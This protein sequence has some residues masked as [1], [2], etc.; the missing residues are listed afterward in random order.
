MPRY[1]F[2]SWDGDRFVPDDEGLDFVGVQE[3]WAAATTGL[4]EMARDIVPN[5]SSEHVMKIRVVDEAGETVGELSLTF[6]ATP[7]LLR[8]LDNECT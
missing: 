3:A 5:L 7:P 6:A 2:P 1:Y 8:G 4:T